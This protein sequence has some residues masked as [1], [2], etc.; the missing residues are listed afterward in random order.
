VSAGIIVALREGIAVNRVLLNGDPSRP[1]GGLVVVPALAHLVELDS[2][3]RPHELYCQS[4]SGVKIGAPSGLF[5]TPLF[6]RIEDNFE[7]VFEGIAHD[8][9]ASLAPDSFLYPDFLGRQTHASVADE[10]YVTKQTNLIGSLFKGRVEAAGKI[11]ECE[12]IVPST[13][14]RCVDRWPVCRR[15]ARQPRTQR[16]A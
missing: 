12:A 5:G 4:Q 8:L 7:V 6:Q 16:R 1:H 14:R 3:K 13:R 2:D 9:Y 11:A 10:V 15:G